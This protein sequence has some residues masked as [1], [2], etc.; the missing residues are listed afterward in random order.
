MFRR[1]HRSK[2]AVLTRRREETT[3]SS[4]Q[5]FAGT[6]VARGRRLKDIRYYKTSDINRQSSLRVLDGLVNWAQSQVAASHLL[7][8]AFAKQKLRRGADWTEGFGGLVLHNH[9][10]GLRVVLFVLGFLRDFAMVASCSLRTGHSVERKQLRAQ[11]GNS[12]VSRDI[13]WLPCQLSNQGK[14]GKERSKVACC[15]PGLPYSF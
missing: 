1:K 6:E 4:K 8:L 10:L 15:F 14:H 7:G 9:G 2:Q 5:T 3:Q 13:G 12:G 11:R